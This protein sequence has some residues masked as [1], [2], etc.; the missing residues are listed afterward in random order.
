MSAATTIIEMHLDGGIACLDFV[1]SAFNTEKEVIVERLHTYSDILI[2]AGRL[3]LLDEKVLKDLKIKS[4]KNTLEADQVLKVA[5]KIRQS[6]FHV[7]TALANGKTEDLS[8]KVLNDF[9]DAVKSA[10]DNRTFIIVEKELIFSWKDVLSNL[11]LPI[12]AFSLSAYE[13]LKNEDQHLIKKCSA[14]EWLFLDKTKNHRRRWCDMQTCGSSEKSR[15]YYQK[16]K[17]NQ[18]QR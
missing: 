8:K 12:W 13:L 16:L 10:L 6:M 15:R 5:R 9:N 1:N 14:C 3:E 18:A 2:L 11:M 17:V 4:E 7:F